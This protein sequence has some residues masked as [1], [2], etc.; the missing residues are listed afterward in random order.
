MKI[1]GKEIASDIIANLKKTETPKKI[2]AAIL[3]GEDPRSLSFIKQKKKVAEE[4]GVKFETRNLKETLSTEDLLKE[5]GKISSEESV[6]GV[7]IQLP[8]PEGVN[9]E[10]VLSVVTPDK[11]VDVLGDV[12]VGKFRN[13]KNPVL[14]PAVGTVEEILKRM[15]VELKNTVVAVVGKGALVGSPISIWLAG[16]CK[17]LYTL[18]SNS[19]RDMTKNADV[20]ISGVGKAGVIDPGALKDGAGVIDFGYYYFPNGDVLGDLK[21]D[22]KGLER[23]AFYTPTPGGTGPILVAKL[24][25]NFYTL[26]K[27]QST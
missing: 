1:D 10:L 18:D 25:E 27:K 4:L 24:L 26:C 13:D 14:P 19:G 8:L 16:K 3:V 22:E 21:L 5:V 7:I 23:L 17:E 20:I 11:D 12:A 9:K 15:S 2:L 6:G